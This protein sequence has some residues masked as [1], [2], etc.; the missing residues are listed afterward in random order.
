MFFMSPDGF[1]SASHGTVFMPWA[2]SR[3]R[4]N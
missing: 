3:A 2:F 1:Q 4:R